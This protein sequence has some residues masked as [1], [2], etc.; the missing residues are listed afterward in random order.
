MDEYELE[1]LQDA[2]YDAGYEAGLF[3]ASPFQRFTVPEEYGAPELREH[4]KSGYS[5]GCFQSHH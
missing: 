4:Y 5:N 2:A 3:S 1:A